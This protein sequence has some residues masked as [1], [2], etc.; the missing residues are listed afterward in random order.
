MFQTSQFKVPQQLT[1]RAA[2]EAFHSNDSFFVSGPE[3]SRPLQ[4]SVQELFVL[5]ASQRSVVKA[6]DIVVLPSKENEEAG[7]CFDLSEDG[8][9]LAFGLGSQEFSCYFTNVGAHPGCARAWSDEN[10][11]EL[12]NN[13]QLDSIYILSAFCPPDPAIRPLQTSKGSRARTSFGT[14]SS[15]LFTTRF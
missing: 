7:N 5:L 3:V 11:S 14:E 1:R 8:E 12:A 13:P 2:D 15:A 4:L 6:R 9:S 10:G